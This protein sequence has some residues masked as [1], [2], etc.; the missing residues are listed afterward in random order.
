VKARRREVRLPG[1]EEDKKVLSSI[2]TSFPRRW[3]ERPA[4]RITGLLSLPHRVANKEV[5]LD[6]TIDH[7]FPTEPPL[8]TTYLSLPF[9]R[10]YQ[11]FQSKSKNQ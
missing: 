10:T 8:R 11:P 2:S 7:S 9:F 5:I 3:K 6:L 4:Q 1:K